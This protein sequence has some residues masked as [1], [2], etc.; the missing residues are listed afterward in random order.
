[1]PVDSEFE[2]FVNKVLKE[3]SKVNAEVE[4]EVYAAL[5]DS[6]FQATKG[7]PD[8]TLDEE[9]VYLASSKEEEDAKI[10]LGFV[11]MAD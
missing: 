9:E 1:M 3:L 7:G 8:H 11:Q 4:I 6:Q 2:T 10:R 5:E